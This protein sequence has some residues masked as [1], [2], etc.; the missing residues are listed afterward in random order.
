M[1]P[2]L[3]W[4]VGENGDWVVGAVAAVGVGQDPR[5]PAV[6]RFPLGAEAV[7]CPIK[8]QYSSSVEQVVKP[9]ADDDESIDRPRQARPPPKDDPPEP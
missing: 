5:L 9:S 3:H 8:W 2:D 1:E 4:P 7:V 6:K